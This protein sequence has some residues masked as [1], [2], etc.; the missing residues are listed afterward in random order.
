LHPAVD[1][2][3]E[4][5]R[6]IKKNINSQL[7]NELKEFANESSDDENEIILKPAEKVNKSGSNDPF[8]VPDQIR[9]D[10]KASDKK[11]E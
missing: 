11:D 6:A 9:R 1:S 2:D 5:I 8:Y 7:D 4:R 3:E 10:K